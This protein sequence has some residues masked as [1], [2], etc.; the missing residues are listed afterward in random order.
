M[1]GYLNKIDFGDVMKKTRFELKKA[2]HTTNSILNHTGGAASFTLKHGIVNEMVMS[3]MMLTY[4]KI[5]ILN[6]V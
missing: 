1:H 6:K 4:F 2:L 3:P 5:N